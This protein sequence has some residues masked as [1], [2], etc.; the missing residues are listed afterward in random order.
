MA[1]AHQENSCC[2]CSEKPVLCC[3]DTKID[4]CMLL[5][6][7]LNKYLVDCR[8]VDNFI[9]D[10][11]LLAWIRL[12]RLVCHLHCSLNTPAV[13]IGIR[14]L[15]CDIL[16]LPQVATFTH[17]CHQTSGRIAYSMGLHQRQTILVIDGVANVFAR[18]AQTPSERSAVKPLSFTGSFV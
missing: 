9:G 17:L 18:F 3:V 6:G 12:A 8:I 1:T 2:S 10:I 4:M 16:E 11:Q 14:Q 13:A 5:H 7:K 15:D